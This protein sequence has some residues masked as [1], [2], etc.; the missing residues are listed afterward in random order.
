MPP[1]RAAVRRPYQLREPLLPR[2][3]YPVSD[4]S[5]LDCLE[6]RFNLCFVGYAKSVFDRNLQLAS[7][8]LPRFV[9]RSDS[10]P[11]SL[12]RLWVNLP[13]SSRDWFK[14]PP[15]DNFL[16]RA[17]TCPSFDFFYSPFDASRA[18]RAERLNQDFLELSYPAGPLCPSCVTFSR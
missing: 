6:D 13:S 2:Q 5:L 14:G 8:G 1:V 16:R 3:T 18:M 11:P 17:L 15:R 12:I 10:S 4:V 9:M 7:N